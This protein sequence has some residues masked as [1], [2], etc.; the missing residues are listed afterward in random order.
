MCVCVCVCVCVCISV[1]VRVLVPADLFQEL[2]YENINVDVMHAER[3]SQQRKDIVR[4]FREGKIWVL[5]CT[6]LM[7][8]GIDFKVRLHCTGG[9]FVHACYCVVV[10]WCHDQHTHTHTHTYAHAHTHTSTHSLF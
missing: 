10:S 7:G 8:R 3:T 6:D 1:R 5:I 4:G 2:V 9:C